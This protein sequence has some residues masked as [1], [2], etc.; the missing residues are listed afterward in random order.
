[1]S[2]IL[3]SLINRSLQGSGGLDVVDLLNGMLVTNEYVKPY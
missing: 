1:M 3:S 2:G